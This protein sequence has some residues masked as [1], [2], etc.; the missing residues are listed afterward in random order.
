MRLTPQITSENKSWQRDTLIRFYRRK[1]EKCQT[2]AKFC[3]QIMFK[4]LGKIWLS[5]TI[6]QLQRFLEIVLR[7]PRP[8]WRH[9]NSRCAW[10]QGLFLQRKNR[11]NITHPSDTPT[12]THFWCWIDSLK[13]KVGNRLWGILNFSGVELIHPKPGLAIDCEVF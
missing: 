3:L 9:L 5:E 10:L 4:Y 1:S 7:I 11:D 12:H 2:L 8:C 13:T 6:S